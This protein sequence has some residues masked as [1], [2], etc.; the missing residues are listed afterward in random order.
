MKQRTEN[1]RNSIKYSQNF[2]RDP[3]L[4][5]RLVEKSSIDSNDMVI[6]IGS[7]RG[8]IA[9]ILSS[10]CRKVIAIETDSGLVDKLKQKFR[11]YSNVQIQA[12]DFL[13]SDLPSEPYKVFSNI[14]FNKTADIIRKLINTSQSPV[15][16]YLI[17]QKESALKY[18]GSPLS[19]ETLFSVTIKPWFELTTEH[20]FQKTDF[21][22]RPSIEIVLLRIRK[23][24]TPLISE[25]QA[26]LYRDFVSYVFNRSNPNLKRGLRDVFTSTQFSRI[27]QTLHANESVTPTQLLFD[28]WLDLFQSF[29][30]LV[31]NNKKMVV[32]GSAAKLEKEQSRLEK[33][34]RTRV[35]KN[36]KKEAIF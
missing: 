21:D 26:K 28:Q 1:V 10:R 16:A 19:K 32:A 36:W 22:P 23:R 9:E 17:V 14:P 31:D 2:L 33:V 30:T 27:S 11:D 18:T 20:N 12:G 15:D 3:Q 25:H 6:D 35:S 29:L 8:V 13:A 5:Q 7:G 24:E 4:V 34:H